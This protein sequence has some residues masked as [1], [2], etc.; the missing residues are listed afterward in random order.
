MSDAL[1][2]VA[3]I[4][5]LFLIFWLAGLH[6]W[7]WLW[8][9]IAVVVGIAELWA[10]LLTGRTLSQHF[11]AYRKAHPVRTWMLIGVLTLAWIGLL[12]HLTWK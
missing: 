5:A 7:A 4:G 12:G 2:A 6:G 8:L 9:A 1:I 11:W 10:K 3:V